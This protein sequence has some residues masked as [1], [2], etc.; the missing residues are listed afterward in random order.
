MLRR[1]RGLLQKRDVSIQSSNLMNV[2]N[3]GMVIYNEFWNRLAI[4]EQSLKYL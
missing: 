2:A 4:F 3:Q 1:G